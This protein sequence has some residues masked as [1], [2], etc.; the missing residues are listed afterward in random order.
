[1]SDE[2]KIQSNEK[3]KS[4]YVISGF[5]GSAIGAVLGLVTYVKSWL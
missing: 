2:S 1:M 5:L 3:N 4:S